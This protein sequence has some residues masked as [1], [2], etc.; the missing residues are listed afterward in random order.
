VSSELSERSTIADPTTG[1]A[2]T[3]DGASW[4]KIDERTPNHCKHSRRGTPVAVKS[5][6]EKPCVQGNIGAP[7][8]E[9]HAVL[10]M[11]ESESSY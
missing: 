5:R 4:L 11:L 6:R 7:H 8:A 3:D 2:E 1:Q 10:I 9:L